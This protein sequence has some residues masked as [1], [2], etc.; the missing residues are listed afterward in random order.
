MSMERSRFYNGYRV[1]SMIARIALP[2]KT[3]RKIISR[4]AC[5][6]AESMVKSVHTRIEKT[7]RLVIR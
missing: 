3:S 4:A 5:K 2:V 1:S 7:H 6:S